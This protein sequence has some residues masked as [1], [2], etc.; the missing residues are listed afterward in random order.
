MYKVI[1]KDFWKCLGP[2]TKGKNYV[3]CSTSNADFMCAHGGRNNGKRHV[4]SASH[5][6]WMKIKS[7]NRDISNM[8]Q[9]SRSEKD[10][11]VTN[12]EVLIC[13]FNGHNR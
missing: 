4:E 13:E 1:Y 7:S 8:L 2:S 12:A 5:N 10:L 6:Q 3:H 11:K 9:A